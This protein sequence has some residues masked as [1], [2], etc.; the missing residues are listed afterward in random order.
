MCSIALFNS[1]Y[2]YHYLKSKETSNLCC[3]TAKKQIPFSLIGK[4]PLK[5]FHINPC[6]FLGSV[7][8]LPS[9]TTLMCVSFSDQVIPF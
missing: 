4:F 1:E 2:I 7:G 3:F 9:K 8:Y 5:S 6:N